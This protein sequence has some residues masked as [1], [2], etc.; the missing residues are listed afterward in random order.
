M[1][2]SLNEESEGD[3]QRL[4]MIRMGLWLFMKV[5]AGQ[6]SAWW[7]PMMILSSLAMVVTQW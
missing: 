7:P 1:E 6:G 3:K 5:T 2:A 4:M